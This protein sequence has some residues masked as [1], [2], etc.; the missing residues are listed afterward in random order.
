M[1]EKEIK[2]FFKYKLSIIDEVGFYEISL[3]EA[4][5]FFFFFSIN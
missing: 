2:V 1:L 5:G 3:L 4:K